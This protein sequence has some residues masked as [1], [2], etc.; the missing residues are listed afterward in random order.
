MQINL[1]HDETLA[2]DKL[3]L[4]YR[5]MNTHI[6]GIIKVATQE[7]SNIEGLLDNCKYLL[8]LSTLYYFES[9]DKKTFAY[10][11]DKVYDIQQPLCD[12]EARLSIYGFV[13][14]NKSVIINLYQVKRLKAQA[15]MRI[16]AELQNGEIQIINRHYKKNFQEQLDRLIHSK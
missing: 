4:A 3:H 11:Y 5:R 15:N 8:D 2:D 16:H 12:I 9:V 6:E 1:L 10:T 14:I 13:R 7:A